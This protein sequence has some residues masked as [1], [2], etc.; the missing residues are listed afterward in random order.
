M[1]SFIVYLKGH[2][3][4]EKQANDCYRSSSSSGFDAEMLEGITPKTL[5]DFEHYP[6]VPNGR[7]TNFKRESKK[8]MRQRCHA[9]L[10]MLRCGKNV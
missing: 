1:K 8:S 10:I 3:A 6:E 7:V 4:S 2:S 5:Y 9:F